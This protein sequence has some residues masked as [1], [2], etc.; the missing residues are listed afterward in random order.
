MDFPRDPHDLQTAFLNATRDAV[1]GNGIVG[2]TDLEVTA[3]SSGMDVNVSSGAVRHN[4]VKYTNGATATLTLSAADDTYD[5][6][7]FIVYDTSADGLAV[8]EG[9]PAPDPNLPSVNDADVTVGMVYVPAD[10]RTVEGDN[11][12]SVS[13]TAATP[14]ADMLDAVSTTGNLTT[15]GESVVLADTS[16]AA[17]TVT[18]SSAD[19]YEGNEVVVKDAGGN[20][21]TNAITIDTEGSETIDGGTSTSVGTNYGSARLVSDGSNWFIA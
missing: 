7:D 12:Y 3:G 4:G 8:R 18:L 6:F 1:E 17:L 16:G 5:R 9:T 21:G 20:A 2:D 10:A 19:A 15:S 14:A 11:I 13:E